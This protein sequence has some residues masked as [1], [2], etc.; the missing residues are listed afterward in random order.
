MKKD[1]IFLLFLLFCAQC[2]SAQWTSVTNGSSGNVWDIAF[3]NENT[4]WYR[5][6]SMFKTTN[7]GQTWDYVPSYLYDSAEISSSFTYRMV[8]RGDTI[9]TPINN[10]RLIRSFNGGSNWQTIYNKF[11]VFIGSFNLVNNVIYA[12]G[13]YPSQTQINLLLK[14]T[15]WGITW[16]SLYMFRDTIQ[17]KGRINF[18]SETI[19]YC[20]ASYSGYFKAS[21]TTNAGRD[22]FPI[23][24]DTKF[25]Q[26][27]K[28]IFLSENEA[29]LEA[30]PSAIYRSLDSGRTF[31][32]MGINNYLN[33]VKYINSTTA[34]MVLGSQNGL[35]YRTTDNGQNWTLILDYSNWPLH[36]VDFKTIAFKN[37]TVYIAAGNSGGV[38]KSTNGGQNFFN[39][40]KYNWQISFASIDFINTTTGFS[41]G[42]RTGIFQTTNSG[43]NWF[44][45]QNFKTVTNIFNRNIF[46][47][48]FA[49]E[50]TGYISTDTGI[51]KSTNAGNN[52]SF[53]FQ[54]MRTNDFYFHNSNTGWTIF[55]YGREGIFKTTDGGNSF[56]LQREFNSYN[57][58]DIEFFDENTGLVTA[59]NGFTSDTLIFRTTNGGQNWYGIN[60]QGDYDKIIK[61]DNDT[62]LLRPYLTGI[63]FMRTTNRGET[64]FLNP[65]SVNTTDMKFVNS[66]LGVASSIH[67]QKYIYTTN[68]G[69]TWNKSMPGL[70]F[71]MYAIYMDKTGFGIIAGSEGR[72][73]RTVNFGGVV[74]INNQYLIIETDYRLNQNYPNP[75][76]AQT[77][78]SFNVN[79]KSQYKVNV[80]DIKGSLIKTIINKFLNSGSYEVAF[81]AENLS[82]GVYFYTLETDNVLI[83]TKKMILMK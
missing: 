5:D 72:I 1:K 78:I 48:D 71:G 59:L 47:I 64:W 16:D 77:I 53:M 60:L 3:K 70:G 23:V 19:G 7:G 58:N 69:Y 73:F 15:D 21:K 9:V 50:H 36:T 82:S 63:G 39:I 44:E 80:Y 43:V 13:Y 20:F 54:S 74:N 31:Q 14:S 61:I 56:N 40:T 57:L 38:F 76:N 27:N 51:Y 12:L 32:S 81:N 46:K 28:L 4:G 25:G 66:N 6:G 34:L 8:N 30:F 33:D 11:N 67:E 41:V 55:Y 24:T 10:K 68:S 79:K 26:V 22:W 2:V 18:I 65:A 37:N 45:N 42:Q 29:Y 62:A 17:N 75:F 83:E 49:D 35:I 52:W